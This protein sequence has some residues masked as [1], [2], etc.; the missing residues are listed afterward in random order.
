MGMAVVVTAGALLYKPI[1][2]DFV[3]LTIKSG[4]DKV[5]LGTWNVVLTLFSGSGNDAIVVA[6]ASASLAGLFIL[7]QRAGS[8][9]VYLTGIAL[10]SATV[11]SMTGAQWI[12]YGLVPARYLSGLL[13]VYL[14]LVAI[15]LVAAAGGLQRLL[16]WPPATKHGLTILMLLLLLMAGPLRSWD[17]AHSQFVNH[18]ANQFDFKPS[19]NA[20]LLAHDSLE[21]E[22]FYTEIAQLHPQGDAVIIE[23]PWYFESNFNPLYLSQQVHGQRVLIG[24]IGGLCAGPLH[25]ELKKGVSGLEFRNFVWLT[26][27][28]AGRVSADYLVLRR[29]GIDGARTID[30]DFDECERAIRERFG[31]PWRSSENALVFRL[32]SGSLILK[33]HVDDLGSIKS[34][35]LP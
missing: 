1:T 21:V 5:N 35:L 24:F 20:I 9:S 34:H 33:F 2:T 8:F 29:A 13:P 6:M 16:N 15:G 28:L 11:V 23:A 31:S 18:L 4:M 3:S 7:R 14:T 19:R 30:M 27:V 25:G 10:L 26:D 22:P 32:D 17:L 12:F